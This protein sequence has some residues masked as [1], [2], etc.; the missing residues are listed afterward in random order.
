MRPWLNLI[1]EFKC[2]VKNCVLVSAIN[3]TSQ[4]RSNYRFKILRDIRSLCL[5]MTSYHMGRI[6]IQNCLNTFTIV[7]AGINEHAAPH[8][9]RTKFAE[10]NA[11]AKT[12]RMNQLSL[13]LKRETRAN[14]SHVASCNSSPAQNMR[15]GRKVEIEL[16]KLVK[17]FIFVNEKN[18]NHQLQ[19]LL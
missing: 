1:K 12:V 3:M 13:R 18:S 19:S 15:T 6:I 11:R 7:K 4:G 17:T 16:K 8:R 5:M 14:I 2:N 10:F 9:M